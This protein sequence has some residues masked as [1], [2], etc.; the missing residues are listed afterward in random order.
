MNYIDAFS[1]WFSRKRLDEYNKKFILY[2]T[3]SYTR[4]KV[5]A[6]ARGNMKANIS[7][8]VNT[9]VDQEKQIRKNRKRA[10]VHD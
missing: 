1:F 3:G 7:I 9:V 8:V 10:N 2:P 4:S 6:R 5:L